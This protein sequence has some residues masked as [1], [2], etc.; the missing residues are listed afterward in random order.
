MAETCNYH[1]CNGA[2]ALQDARTENDEAGNEYTVEEY[3]CEFGH[4]FHETL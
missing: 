4:T 1:E 3:E 2:T